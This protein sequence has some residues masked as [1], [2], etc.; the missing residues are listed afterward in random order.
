MNSRK[1]IFWVLVTAA[2][3]RLG[4]LGVAM[5][6]PQRMRTPDSAGYIALAQRLVEKGEF[7][8]GSQPE[9]FRT[10]GYPS[11]LC[12]AQKC[13]GHFDLA[14]G[15]LQ[16]AADLLLV[17]LT[18]RLGL[19]LCDARTAAWAALFQA[20]SPVSAASSVRILSDGLFAAMLACAILLLVNHLRSGRWRS[21]IA[22]AVVSAA[23]CYVRPV[24][25]MFCVI[26]VGV[27]LLRPRRIHAVAFACV[28][29][30]MIAPWA[31]RNGV[32]ARYWGFSSFGSDSLYAFGLPP[33]MAK[34]E[35]VSVADARAKLEAMDRAYADENPDSSPGAAARD[36]QQRI[37]KFLREH[38]LDYLQ[39]HLKGDVS[40]FLPGATDV[41]EVLGLTTGNRGTLEVYQQ[42][43]LFAAARHY[44]DQSGWSLALVV[45]AVG[46]L[47]GQYFLTVLWLGAK[48]RLRMP[49]A[50]W[51]ILLTFAAFAL[52][53]GAAATPRFRVPVEPL[54]SLVSAAGLM[55]VLSWRKTNRE[56]AGTAVQN[57]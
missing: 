36:R 16:I 23:A 35:G 7:S 33:A 28:A 12:L 53:G 29:V 31:I 39:T 18:Y 50:H 20:V 57:R 45:P 41:L 2:V 4:L 21:L 8:Q 3:I 25:I 34:A 56:R 43:G 22:A 14:A 26:A 5:Q 42:K 37:A 49:A 51:L 6:S 27:L 54:L 13:D 40:F 46:L 10:P 9:I 38:P 1:A 17:Y 48:V 32:E 15:L 44:F 11:F 24:G 55:L 52:V 19:V 47:A 30:A